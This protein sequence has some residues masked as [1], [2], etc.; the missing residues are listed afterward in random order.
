M[1]SVELKSSSIPTRLKSKNRVL[2][3]DNLEARFKTIPKKT[4]TIALPNLNLSMFPIQLFGFT[5][6]TYLDL[7]E[8]NI[9]YIPSEI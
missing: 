4:Q 9:E 5:S 6:L 7:G 1:K 2:G 8:N 3:G